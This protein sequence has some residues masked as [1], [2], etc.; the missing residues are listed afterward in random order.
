MS[1]EN[2]EAILIGDGNP[3]PTVSP[4]YVKATDT[5]SYGSYIRKTSSNSGNKT[6]IRLEGTNSQTKV[7]TFT[8][9]LINPDAKL[10]TF[11]S[12]RVTFCSTPI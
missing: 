5:N 3:S 7:T 2:F 11:Y 10:T 8:E 6:L 1:L 12:R 4:L 9:L